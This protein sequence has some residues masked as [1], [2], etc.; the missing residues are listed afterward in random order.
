MYII[1]RINEFDTIE[2]IVK[3]FGVTEQNISNKNL[4]KKIQEGD[5]IVI[6]KTPQLVHVVM[7]GESI[8]SIAK[9]YNVSKDY[10]I[11][12]NGINKI[13]NGLNLFI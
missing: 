6:D 10:L 12:K 4:T 5:R 13:F 11:K 1:Y 3:K 9:L 8:E 7:P 2:S